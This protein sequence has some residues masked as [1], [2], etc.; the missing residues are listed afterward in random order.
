[1]R[2]ETSAYWDGI[3]A[4][5]DALPAGWRRHARREHLRLI[6]DWARPAGLWLKTDLFE[7]R[8][9]DRA[10]LPSLDT[11]SWVGVDLSTEVAGQARSL[12]GSRSVV[13]DIRSLPFASGTFDGVL[14]TSTLDHFATTAS[15]DRS[16]RE[17][18][19]VLRP[20]GRLVLTL[21]NPRNPLIR[22]RNAMPPEWARRTGLAPFAV[23]CT[24]DEAD[25]RA[26][27]RSA[28]FEV[29][30]TA[31]LLHAPHVVGTR[32][33]RFGWYERSVLPRTESAG[34]SRLARFTGHYVA[35]S[36]RAT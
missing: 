27:L 22:L 4:D 12:I 9:A 13:A 19:R 28:G 31:H 24:L 11:A 17:L 7:E 21:D 25:G 15:I 6:A 34:R 5:H 23:G 29:D 30:A 10:L 3:A 20:D 33:A 32:A 16:L 36:A 26:A 1:M 14:S 18:R 2:E 8:S 35:F